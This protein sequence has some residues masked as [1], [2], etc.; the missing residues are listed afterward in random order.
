M[1]INAIV[2]K[3]HSERNKNVVTWLLRAGPSRTPHSKG[4][5]VRTRDS[6]AR[7]ELPTY[8]RPK[9]RNVTEGE[10]A[11]GRPNG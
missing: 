8:V 5:L 11:E 2:R 3:T 10:C 9:T 7:S 6:G 4:R 1:N